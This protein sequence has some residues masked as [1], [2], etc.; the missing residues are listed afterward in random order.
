MRDGS[1]SCEGLTGSLPSEL[2]IWLSPTFPVGGFAYSQGL[3]AA[4]AKGWVSDRETLTSWLGCVVTHGGWRNELILLSLIVRARNE[5]ELAELKALS[6]A[7]QPSA[8]RAK[9]ACDQG[10]SFRSAYLAAWAPQQHSPE[11]REAGL[12]L[13]AAVGLAARDYNMST[14]A[15]LEAYTLAFI[16]NQISAAIRLNTVGQFDGQRITADLLPELRS[17]CEQCAI[18]SVDDLGSAAFGADLA[19]LLHETQTTRL[20]RS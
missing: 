1:T 12:T 18:A 7:L 2:L 8:E 6:A 10:Q 14:A 16:G 15:V 13:T 11:A 9:E 19:S 3:E 4:V 17:L 20:F 5:V